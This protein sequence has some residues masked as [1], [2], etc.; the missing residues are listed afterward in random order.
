MKRESDLIRTIKFADSLTKW[1]EIYE[2]KPS[3]QTL[4][5]ISTTITIRLDLKYFSFIFV[6]ISC[7]YRFHLESNKE[8]TKL[9]ILCV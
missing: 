1:R 9:L 6:F 7:N 4:K 3:E 5:T 8:N 2:T